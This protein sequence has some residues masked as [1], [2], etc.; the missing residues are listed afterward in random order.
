MPKITESELKKGLSGELSGVYFLYGEE[1]FLVRTYAEKIV[2][3]AVAGAAERT[4]SPCEVEIP[5]GEE[6]VPLD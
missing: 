1:D 3:A 6:E 4:V 5:G 2:A